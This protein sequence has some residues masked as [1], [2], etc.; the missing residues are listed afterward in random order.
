VDGI[1]SRR[2][3]R[4]VALEAASAYIFLSAEVISEF[5]NL[6]TST[7][8]W[9]MNHLVLTDVDA[10]VRNRRTKEDE[11]SGLKIAP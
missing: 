2:C 7:R 9:G 8:A 10:H 11:I 5:S 3:G 4:S 6:Y 1:V